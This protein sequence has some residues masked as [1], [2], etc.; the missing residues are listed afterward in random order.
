MPLDG[1]QKASLWR[2]NGFDDAILGFSR[3]AQQWRD[4]LD[5]LVMQAV[6]GDV[7]LIDQLRE[8]RSRIEADAVHQRGARTAGGIGMLDRRYALVP[9]I[10]PEAAGPGPVQ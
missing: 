10:L 1:N 9:E 2:F 3:H 5:G 4:C 8:P 7:C 6:D